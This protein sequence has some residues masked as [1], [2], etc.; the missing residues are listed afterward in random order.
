MTKLI[1]EDFFKL[2]RKQQEELLSQFTTDFSKKDKEKDLWEKYER[3]FGVAEVSEKV[4]EVVEKEV[5][6]KNEEVLP[7]QNKAVKQENL[8]LCP[9][10]TKEKLTDIFYELLKKTSNY[11]DYECK[12]CWRKTT[13]FRYG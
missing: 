2:S 3:H 13:I 8:P 10:C 7:P 11:S 12:S 1:K 4:E 9:V 6:V 5:E